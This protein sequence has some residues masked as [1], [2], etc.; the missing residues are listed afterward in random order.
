MENPYKKD[1]L[2]LNFKDIVCDR[3]CRKKSKRILLLSKSKNYINEKISIEY[4]LKKLNE[5]D[6]IKF[7]IF[8]ED[9][10]NLL[11]VVP[12]PNFNDIF[13]KIKDENSESL[14]KID[15]L[16]RKYDFYLYNF[17]EER[18]SYEKLKVDTENEINNKIISMVNNYYS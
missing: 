16:W 1:I 5:L 8:N 3:L 12:N 11:N 18:E 9:Q 17:K 14:S 13:D 4:I 7:I 6:K 2:K 15:R 10:L